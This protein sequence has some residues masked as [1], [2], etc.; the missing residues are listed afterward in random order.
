MV[1]RLL[2]H[3]VL[4]DILGSRNVYFQPPESIKLNYPCMIYNLSD[5]W[6]NKA[7]DSSYVTRKKYTIIIIDKNPDS[8]IGDKLLKLPYC[9]F[10]RSYASDG[11]NHFVYS[12]YF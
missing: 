2:L 7:S 4:V 5:I 9:S 3:Q 8:Q 12:L 11:L 10:D 1:N 6:S